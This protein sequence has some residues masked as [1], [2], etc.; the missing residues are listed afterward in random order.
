MRPPC[1]LLRC[2]T[3]LL[4][5]HFVGAC[6]LDNVGDPPPDADIYFPT[7]LFLSGQSESSAPRFLYLLNSNY[8]LRYNRGSVQAFDLDALD[9]ELS[10]CAEPGLECQIASSKVMVDEVLVPSL[11]T[12]YSVSPDRRRLYVATRTDQSLLYIDLDESADGEDI[13]QCDESERRCSDDRRRGADAADNARGVTLPPEPVGIVTL[14]AASAVPGLSAD[15]APGDFVL[16]AH[17][18]GQV[19]LFHD[20]GAGGPRLIHVADRLPV[21]PTG[22][23]FDPVGHIAY[24]SLSTSARSAG[25]SSSRLLGR[26]AFSVEPSTNG[27]LDASYLYDVGAVFIDGVAP[28]RSSRSVRMNPAREGQL[29]VTGD[30]PASLLFVDVGTGESSGLGLAAP[31]LPA[32]EIVTIGDGPL[33]MAHGKIGERE[34][35][36]V[37]CFD[38]KQLYL[39]DAARSTIAAVIHNLNGPFDLAIDSVRQRLYLADFRSSSALVVDVSALAATGADNQRTDAIIIGMLGI[40]K[41]VQELQ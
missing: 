4:G 16:V 21:E 32:R 28:Q 7:G 22:I 15:S 6:N 2:L 19:S 12:S 35:I 37:A 1:A 39:I 11:A 41:V 18:F 40:P 3:A 31:S 34:I 36:A 5:L 25:S 38:A 23:E 8:D 29:L 14:P 30:R 27:S 9:A 33:R 10:S 20:A 26:L 24:L 17:R 13:L